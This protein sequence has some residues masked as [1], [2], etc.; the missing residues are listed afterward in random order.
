MKLRYVLPLAAVVVV[1]I[2]SGL[3]RRPG[4][5]DVPPARKQASLAAVRARTSGRVERIGCGITDGFGDCSV[6]TAA[7]GG[8]T[9]AHWWAHW[10]QD[11]PV[12]VRRLEPA[13]CLPE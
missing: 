13:A 2:L 3:I 7:A 10:F 1:A 9:C 5:V 8:R 11:G 12:R 6:L 4:H